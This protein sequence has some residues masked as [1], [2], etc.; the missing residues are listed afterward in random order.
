MSLFFPNRGPSIGKA[1]GHTLSVTG[2][3]VAHVALLGL[4][5]TIVPTDRLV[6]IVRP[7]TARLIESAAE[8]SPPPSPPP[9]QP[10]RQKARAVAQKAQP[11]AQPVLV[12]STTAPASEAPAFVVAPQPST[13]IAARP[14]A[15]APEAAVVAARF[16]ADYLDNPR[17][18]YPRV[19]RKLGEEG[20]VI[21]RVRVNAAG[22]PEH[23]ELKHTSGSERLDQAALDTVIRW[24]FVPARRGDEAIAS[25]VLVP[26]T[27][28]LEG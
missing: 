3:A 18:A 8:V 22:R 20:K 4:A 11:T 27:F 21:L 28:K 26:I 10:P 15:P 25:W 5:A 24:R 1:R 12:A 16:D 7:F 2:A 6:D 17:P 13:P 23:I 19:S 14:I 9:Q